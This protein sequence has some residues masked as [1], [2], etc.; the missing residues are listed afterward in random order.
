MVGV[1]NQLVTQRR[2]TNAPTFLGQLSKK[3]F[4][5]ELDMIAITSSSYRTT[6]RGFRR[7]SICGVKEGR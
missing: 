4:P 6:S 5:T 2:Q 3:F 1:H 7:Q